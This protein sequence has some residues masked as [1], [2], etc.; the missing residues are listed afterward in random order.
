MD[1]IATIFVDKDFNRY[2]FPRIKIEG[3]NILGVDKKFLA[4]MSV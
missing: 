1:N 2:T 4:D 3:S